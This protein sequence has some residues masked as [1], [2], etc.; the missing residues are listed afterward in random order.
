[1]HLT[2]P[3]E[4]AEF[5]SSLGVSPASRLL[6]AED[7]AAGER[8][9][10]YDAI[11]C[12]DAIAELE[13]RSAALESW[14]RIVKPGGRILYTDPAIV[15]GLITSEELA[16]RS[17]M[18]LLVFSPQGENE[19]LIEDTGL[20]MLRADDAT[21]SIAEAAAARRAERARREAALVADEGRARFDLVQRYL[22]ITHLLASERRL[23]RIAFLLEKPA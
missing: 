11:L 8:D 7:A 23:A 22:E 19:S 10:T 6:E 12:I 4:R 17:S 3:E 2:S 13:D 18:G 21:D 9:D 1:M 14:A 5:L 16:H 20:R 15:A